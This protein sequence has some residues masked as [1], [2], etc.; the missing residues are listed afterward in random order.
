MLEKGPVNPDHHKS[1]KRTFGLTVE[2]GKKEVQHG[3]EGR[4]WWRGGKREE[5]KAR[6]E[7]KKL[8]IPCTDGSHASQSLSS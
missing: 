1:R 2:K 7:E 3:G 8:R 5:E 6:M 4:E